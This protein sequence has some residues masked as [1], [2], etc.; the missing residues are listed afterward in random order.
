MKLTNA[1]SCRR[2]WSEF[3]MRRALFSHTRKGAIDKVSLNIEMTNWNSSWSLVHGVPERFY[4]IELVGLSLP[5]QT[6]D[7]SFQPLDS[8]S[9]NMER[10]L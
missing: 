9:L 3:H 10:L 1:S 6:L 2:V 8:F 5:P 7:L 4:K